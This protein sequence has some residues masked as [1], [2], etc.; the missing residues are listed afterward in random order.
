[1]RGATAYRGRSV[2]SCQFSPEGSKFQDSARTTPATA[3]DDPV[4]SWTDLGTAATHVSQA[5]AANRPLLKLAVLNGYDV[6]DFDGVND[7]LSA[8]WTALTGY[9]VFMVAKKKSA[10]AAA[11]KTLLGIR[12]G[13][14]RL[15]PLVGNSAGN[16]NGMR[17]FANEAVGY[18]EW[19]NSTVTNWNIYSFTVVSAAVCHLRVNGGL[20]AVFDPHDIATTATTF[21]FCGDNT[22]NFGDYQVAA[23]RRYP[24]ALELGDNNYVGKELGEKYALTWNEAA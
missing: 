6:L 5:T 3:G 1:M 11:E 10:L 16:A 9:T 20:A 7:S 23:L 18:Q 22:T 17:F 15:R 4:G 13:S 19:A 2:P 21:Q 12:Q 14:S 24:K 8:A